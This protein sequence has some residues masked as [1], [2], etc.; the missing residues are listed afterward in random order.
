MA[1]ADKIADFIATVKKKLKK[2]I[3]ADDHNRKEAVECLR[4]LNGENHWNAD[5]EKQ[6]KLEGRPCLKVNLFPAFVNQVVGEMLHNRAR[7]KIKPGDHKASAHLAKIRSG[8]ISNAEYRSNGEDIYMTAGKTQVAC[9]YGAW[10]INTRY[11]EENPFIQEF[12]LEA[13]PN[14]LTVYLDSARKDE[15][16]ADAKH[17]FILT[18][19][20]REEFKAEWPHAEYPTE[21]MKVGTGQKDELHYD[22][23]H[24]TVCEYFVVKP[25]KVKMCMMDDGSVITEAEAEKKIEAHAELVSKLLNGG[26]APAAPPGASPTPASAPV[27]PM[28]APGGPPPAAPPQ[29]GMPPIAPVAPQL[30]KAPEIIDRRETTV[31]QVKHYTLTATEI[32]GPKKSDEVSESEHR[33]KLLDGEDVPGEYVPIV[34]ALGITLNIEGKTHCK[35]L[36]RDGRDA[37]KLVSYWETAIAEAIALAPK[38]PWVMTPKQ[39][40]GYEEDYKNANVKN[41]PFLL[42]NMDVESGVPAPPPMRQRP[43]DPPAA[44]FMQAS[45][46]VD[47]LKRVLGMFGADIGEAGPER[48]GAAVYAKQKPGDISTYVYA[49]KLNRAIEHS[50]KIMNSMIGELY[51]TERDVRLRNIDDTEAVVPINTTVE[52]A[53]RK[54]QGAPQVY[55][56]MNPLKLTQAYQRGD[57]QAKFNDITVGKYE[58]VVTVGPSYATAR[59]ESSAQ[60]LSLINAVPAIGKVGADIIVEGID[61]TQS[62]RLAARLRK[63]LPPGLVEP[64]EGEKPYQPPIP[65]QVQLI[66]QKSKTEAIKQQKEVL[67]TRVELVRLYKE[68]QESEVEV[69]KEVLSILQELH[70]PPGAG[71]NGPVSG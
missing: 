38:A 49:Y 27:P 25:K 4:M 32:L 7:A 43:A 8:I 9:G 1:K 67:K 33:K 14:P 19:M 56:G 57:D 63:T 21:T 36:I 68:T 41:N 13:I 65:P 47:N 45:R 71:G 53:L 44:L 64:R 15:S 39:V 59:Q 54:L 6:R 18:R 40:D 62:E 31:R 34:M 5:D 30:P 16:G 20:P 22:K 50:A 66:A 2:D 48:T 17:G 60:L 37:A 46:A 11:C 3:D 23:D 42:Y 26:N 12:Y 55:K 52:R 28:P 35:G 70:Q 58:V 24:V 51:D 29:P 10:R 61:G 69:R